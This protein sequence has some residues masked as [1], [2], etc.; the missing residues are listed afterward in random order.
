MLER[1]GLTV[2]RVAM[3]AVVVGFALW[4]VELTVGLSGWLR[5]A[6]A[7][8]FGVAATCVVV[9]RTLASAG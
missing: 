4:L 3:G 6:P 9:A 7:A 8:S 2:V 1:I 5:W